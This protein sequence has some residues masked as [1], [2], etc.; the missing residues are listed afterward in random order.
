MPHYSPE[1]EKGMGKIET[2]IENLERMEREIWRRVDDMEEREEDIEV[3]LGLKSRISR[4]YKPKFI[5]KQ[6][7]DVKRRVKRIRRLGSERI[8]KRRSRM[9]R[10]I[11]DV[12]KKAGDEVRGGPSVVEEMIPWEEKKIQEERKDILKKQV[13]DVIEK[14]KKVKKENR[15]EIPGE[16]KQLKILTGEEA[17]DARILFEFLLKRGSAS[18][19][20]AVKELDADKETVSS[21]GDDLKASGLIDVNEFAGRTIM[22]LRDISTAI[23]E[24]KKRAGYISSL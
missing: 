18:L 6:V 23:D 24:K 22:K 17:S 20:D 13:S 19:E 4:T 15:K 12:V 9:Q 10:Q 2:R 1:L 7:N 11:K 14:Y 5:K 21:W 8:M 16:I 3:K